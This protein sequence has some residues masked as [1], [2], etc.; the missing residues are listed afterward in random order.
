MIRIRRKRK[1]LKT[2]ED[3]AR[4]AAKAREKQRRKM[5]RTKFGQAPLRHARKGIYACFY[6][7]VVLILLFLM[8]LISYVTKGEVGILIG[9]V[10]LGTV[11]L[12]AAGLVL[13]IRGLKERD[14]NYITCKVGIAMNGVFL[15]G[16][17]GTIY[18]G[19]VVR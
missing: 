11:A 19:A 15:A 6:G 7:T 3:R 13:G 8:I 2:E 1:R 4:A 16:L 12:S 9:L 5:V 17:A 14:K 18:Q 10:G